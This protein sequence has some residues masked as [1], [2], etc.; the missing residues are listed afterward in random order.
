MK[1]S[2]A[3]VTPLALSSVP[4][5]FFQSFIQAQQYLQVKA[6]E[7][8][9][10]IKQIRWIAPHTFPIDANRNECVAWL[11]K[12]DIDVSVWIDADQRLEM[13]TLFK[14]LSKGDD[15]PVYAGIYHL[16][17]PDYYPIIFHTNDDFDVFSPIYFYPEEDLFYADMIGMGCVKIDREVFDKLERPYFKYSPIPREI[18]EVGDIAKFK[19]E[20]DVHDVS[21]DVYFWRQVRENTDFKIVVDPT[22]QVGHVT[23]IS[24]NVNNFIG[25]H[26][27]KRELM[28]KQI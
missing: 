26:N 24:I 15:Y 4:I 6:G 13:D 27:Y 7:L 28:I 5:E 25:Y 16:K 3:I 10:E 23:D 8:P 14:L 12:W 1:K 19:Y 2:I 11:K 20:N 17:K 22:I 18:S 9:F 21:E